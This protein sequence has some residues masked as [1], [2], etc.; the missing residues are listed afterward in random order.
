MID[1][2]NVLV[3]GTNVLIHGVNLVK[4]GT[5]V[6]S[7]PEI[8]H[9]SGGGLVVGTGLAVVHKGETVTPAGAGS[10]ISGELTLTPDG[11]A[12]VQGVVWRE[13]ER[14]S[15]HARALSRMGRRST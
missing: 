6:P 4:P 7:I 3:R 15:R 2:L 10:T 11:R 14:S 9:L 12:F 13:G 5:D 1:G 8:P